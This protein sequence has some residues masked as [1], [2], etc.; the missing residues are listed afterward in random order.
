MYYVLGVYVAHAARH[1]KG[2]GQGAQGG[3]AAG[4]HAA[5]HAVRCEWADGKEAR[6]FSGALLAGCC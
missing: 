6:V 4:R 1:V 2:Q 5:H 3:G